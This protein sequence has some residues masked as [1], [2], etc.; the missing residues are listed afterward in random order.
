MFAELL[1]VMVVSQAEP[2]ASVAA[3]DAGV[4]ELDAGAVVPVA[5]A[6]PL[7]SFSDERVPLALKKPALAKVPA[8]ELADA[9]AKVKPDADREQLCHDLRELVPPALLKVQSV[10]A[11][12]DPVEATVLLDGR[13]VGTAPYDAMV[14]ACVKRVVIQRGAEVRTEDVVLEPRGRKT[15]RVDWGG[16][17]KFWAVSAMSDVSLFNPSLKLVPQGAEPASAVIG[18]G[19]RLESF[20]KVFHFSVAV[21]VNPLYGPL[22]AAVGLR[23]VPVVPTVDLFFGAAFRPGNST[24]RAVIAIDGGLWQLLSPAVRATG[25]V[26]LFERVLITLNVDAR[27]M[28]VGFVFP[29]LQMPLVSPGFGGAAGFAW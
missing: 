3:P 15:V 14:P 25:G 10:D 20:A 18:A 1:V 29:T 2:D 23:G 26:L 27:L 24:V 16:A 11:N 17:K 4:A 8:T 9:I 6:P 21:N 22:L 28:T 7:D 19:V 12:D 13:E 5:A